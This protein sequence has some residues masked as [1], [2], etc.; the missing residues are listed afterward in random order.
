MNSGSSF[1]FLYG[2]HDWQK[3][4]SKK[5]VEVFPVIFRSLS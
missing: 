2:W 4:K 1:G 5:F 3:S